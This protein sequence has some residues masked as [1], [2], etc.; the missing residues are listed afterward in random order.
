MARLG[1][2]DNY[3]F[4]ALLALLFTALA[5]TRHILIVSTILVL[6]LLSN[7]PVEFGLNFGFDRDY[8]AGFMLALI[9]QPVLVRAL[10]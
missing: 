9:F 7:M 1:L 8:Y 5:A 10:D 3:A 6:S 2:A 4:I